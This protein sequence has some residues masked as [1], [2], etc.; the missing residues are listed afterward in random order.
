[1]SPQNIM[2]S[3][4][5]AVKIVDFGIAKAKD[6]VDETRSGVIKGKFGYMSPEQANGESVDHRTD[7]FSTGIILFELLTGKRLFAAESDM[8]TLRQIQDCVIPQPS[9]LNPK[10]PAELEKILLKALAKDIK[11]RYQNAGHFHRALLE[12][13][14]KHYPAY[15]AR[16]AAELLS[17]TFAEEI[18]AEK[19]RFEQ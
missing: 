14:N 5:G 19:R 18:V 2:L 9:R 10:I 7:I 11:L 4:E 15:T 12:F 1:M 8:A 17:R 3:Y 13:L 16:E 6:R